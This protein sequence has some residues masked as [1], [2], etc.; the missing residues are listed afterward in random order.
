MYK[1]DISEPEIPL[2]LDEMNKTETIDDKTEARI[3]QEIVMWYRNNFC[4]KHHNPRCL[5]MSIPNSNQKLF[6]EVGMVAGASDL[7]VIR[8]RY[9]IG[10]PPIIYF[11]EVKTPKG[12]QSPKQKTFQKHI[13]QMGMEYYIVRSLEDFKKIIEK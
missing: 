2:K 9:D 13:E 1:V 7:M 8:D 4:L 5:I 11:I 6:R 10:S 12:R 3:Q